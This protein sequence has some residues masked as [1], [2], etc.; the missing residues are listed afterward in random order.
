MRAR[1]QALL[2]AL[3]LTGA[4]AGGLCLLVLAARHNVRIDLTPERVHSLTR[5]SHEVLERLDRDVTIT[6]LYDGQTPSRRREMADLL[7]RYAGAASRI[8]IRLLDLDRHPGL[9]RRLG[10]TRYNTGVVAGDRRLPLGIVDEAEI[11]G[12]LLRLV[13]PVERTVYFTVG[14]GEHDPADGDERRG[15]SDLAR[16]LQDTGYAVARLDGLAASGVPPDATAV[17]V[18]GPRTAFATGGLDALRAYVGG[19]GAVL[20]LLD[21]EAPPA[22]AAFLAS[23]GLRPSNDVVVDERNAL[24]GAD[25]LMPRIP[26]LNQSVFPRLPELPAVLPEAQSIALGDE[27]PGVETTYLASAAEHA[28][29]D[30]DRGSVTEETPRFDPRADHRGPIPVAALA[31]VATA[32][33]G[34]SGDV[35]VV[36]DADFVSNLYLGLLGNRDVFLALL[37]LLT[38]RELHGAL[39]PVP[40][41]G[42][43]SP[44]TLTRRQERLVLWTTVILPP[45]MVLL[46]WGVVAARRRRRLR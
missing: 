25:N 11:T 21:P 7:E 27:V 45:A 1:R 42:S 5:A 9:A 13:D 16:S 18:G 29:A 26:Y 37:D 46:G 15:Y 41:G 2:F 4:A 33:G 32:H 22:F 10:I 23:Y 6:V 43:L 12:A 24:L 8:R 38:R 14:H 20:W 3:Q 35:A 36:G 30:V 19:G 31:R 28:W 44:L 40:P 17:V 34:R 39:R